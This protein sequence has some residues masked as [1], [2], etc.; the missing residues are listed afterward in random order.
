MSLC[1]RE[2]GDAMT[3]AIWL[4]G[5]ITSIIFRISAGYPVLTQFFLQFLLPVSATAT[6]PLHIRTGSPQWWEAVLASYA[7]RRVRLEFFSPFGVVKF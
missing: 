7:C 5:T 4:C 6:G 2:Y 1:G 3:V